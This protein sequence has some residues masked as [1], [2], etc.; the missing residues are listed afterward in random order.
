MFVISESDQRA[1][2][3]W[4]VNDNKSKTVKNQDN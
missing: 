1:L 3:A 2:K 4:N